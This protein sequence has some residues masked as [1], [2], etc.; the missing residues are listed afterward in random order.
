MIK[1]RHGRAWAG[2]GSVERHRMPSGARPEVA[3]SGGCSLQQPEPLQGTAAAPPGGDPSSSW[4]DPSRSHGDVHDDLRGVHTGRPGP[5]A[6]TAAGAGERLRR[7]RASGADH[8]LMRAHA[9][10]KQARQ[11]VDGDGQ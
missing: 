6:R 7:L 1:A 8:A 3:D 2:P 10:R 9:D 5:P 11:G 4:P